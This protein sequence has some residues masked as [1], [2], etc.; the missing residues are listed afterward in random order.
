MNLREIRDVFIKMSG[1]LDLVTAS[2]LDAG[3]NFFINGGIRLLNSLTCD[4]SKAVKFD[5]VDDADSC[6]WSEDYPDILIHASL[7]RLEVSYRNTAGAND[8]L[9][10]VQSDLMGL[11][12]EWVEEDVADIDAMEG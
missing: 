11:D 1:R 5:L 6:M 12:K 3:A 4:S 9:V 8:W 7:Q 10:S 2:G